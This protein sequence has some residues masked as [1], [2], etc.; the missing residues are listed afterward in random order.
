MYL[1]F[2]KILSLFLIFSILMM[3]CAYTPKVLKPADTDDKT[4]WVKYYKDQFRAY[5]NKVTPPPDDAPD[6]Q[7]SAYLAAKH[8]WVRSRVVGTI[9]NVVLLTLCVSLLV[10]TY[11][12]AQQVK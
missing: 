1:L 4:A 10:S 11:S 5:G 3:G 6:P 9:L 2:K 8:S 7:K 12:Q